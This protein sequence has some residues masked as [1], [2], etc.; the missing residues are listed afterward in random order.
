M[1]E[2]GYQ[3]SIDNP[4]GEC[5]FVVRIKRG[6]GNRREVL[7][8]LDHKVAPLNSNFSNLKQLSHTYFI[9][10]I[11]PSMGFMNFW[12]FM[13]NMIR[14]QMYSLL[15]EGQKGKI[16]GLVCFEGWRRLIISYTIFF[17]CGLDITRSLLL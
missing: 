9:S 12:I 14:L 11:Q 6:G 7:D 2:R 8:R 16:F 15:A 13:P 4:E 5:T 3:G 10:V 17:L 1:V